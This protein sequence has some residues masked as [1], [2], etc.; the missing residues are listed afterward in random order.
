MSRENLEAAAISVGEL[1]TKKL[2]GWF[3]EEYAR[4]SGASEQDFKA[5]VIR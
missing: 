5:H 2:S 4:T 3:K 1:D